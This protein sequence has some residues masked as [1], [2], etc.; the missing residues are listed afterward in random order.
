MPRLGLRSVGRTHTSDVMAV[1]LPTWNEKRETP[2]RVRT[3]ISAVMRWAEAQGYRED[4]PAGEAI[5]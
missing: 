2:K 1:L 4:N 3:R 5:G